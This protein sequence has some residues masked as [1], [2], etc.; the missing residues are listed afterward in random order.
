MKKLFILA[1]AA[2][3]AL[4]AC[5]KTQMVDTP[6][7]EVSFKIA[8]YTAQT[9]AYNSLLDE[10]AD[11][12]PI[13]S[14][15]TNAWYHDGAGSYGSQVFMADQVIKP[16]NTTDPSYWA[17][18]GR[19][20]YWPKT[21]YVNFF[22]YAGSPAPTAKAEGS[23]TYTNVAVVPASNILVAEAAYRYTE[24]TTNDSAIY[25]QNS[26]TE[27]VPT[28][29]H[30]ILAKVKFDVVLDAKTGMTNPDSKD[31]W[32]VSITSASINVPQQGTINLTFTDP[33]SKGT[34]KFANTCKWAS[35][36]NYT[37]I[38]NVTGTGANVASP[39][40]YEIDDAITLTAIG[41]KISKEESRTEYND[42]T[43]KPAELIAESAVIPHQLGNDVTFTMT[44]KL[45][46]SY[47]GG[48]PIQEVV[49]VP[50][51]KLTTF[52]PQIDTWEM[53]TIYTYHIIIKPN[54]EVLFDPAVETWVAET[55]EPVLTVD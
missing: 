8:N 14:F 20:Y 3:V 40:N 16:E 34:A 11:G 21:G 22:S 36:A 35:L 50:A 45:A 27:G 38:S 7:R 46:Y 55:N 26:V 9:K 1:A 41:G 44:Y 19:K 15:T 5:T 17:A 31:K 52:A 39:E 49:T 12:N 48:A 28:L 2:V 33:S 53:N 13:V 32:T 37:A 18:D 10:T 6:S 23:I 51:T 43:K 47:D 54:A 42:D 25:Q 30:H 24:N 4:A 29:F